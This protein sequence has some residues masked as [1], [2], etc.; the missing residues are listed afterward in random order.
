ML[1]RVLRRSLLPD[2]PAYCCGSAC[3]LSERYSACMR[4][5]MLARLFVSDGPV[6]GPCVVLSGVSVLSFTGPIRPIDA[7]G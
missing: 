1:R 2:E 3:R 6:G 4:A 7:W 5:E